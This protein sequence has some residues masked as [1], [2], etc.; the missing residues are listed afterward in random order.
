[1]FNDLF[2][3]AGPMALASAGSHGTGKVIAAGFISHAGA[4]T[5]PTLRRACHLS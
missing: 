4:A 5:A 3:R 2:P 1:M